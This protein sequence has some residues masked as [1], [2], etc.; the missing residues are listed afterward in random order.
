MSD[1]QISMPTN[2]RIWL[3]GGT[4]ESAVL[5]EAIAHSHL[6]C[7]ITVTTETA[8]QLY[9][10]SPLLRVKVGRLHPDQMEDF[11]QAENIAAI[12]DASHPHAVEIS[13]LAIATATKN[14]IPYLRYER[15]EVRDFPQA[16]GQEVQRFEVR[17][18]TLRS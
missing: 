10:A 18:S 1:F 13:Q 6:P 9:L 3:I 5:A 8:K 4:S 11:L 2:Y 16:G 7:T 17:G 15:L 12:L 14:Q